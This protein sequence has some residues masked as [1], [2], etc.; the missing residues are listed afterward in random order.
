MEKAGNHILLKKLL[1]VT[2]AMFGFGYAMVPFYNKICE[3][4][5]INSD[6]AQVLAKNSQVDASRT[7]TLEFDANVDAKLPWKFVPVQKSMTVHPGEMV[8]VLYEVENQTDQNIT[9]Q[10]IPSYG[11]QLAGQYVK[12]IECFCFTGQTLKAHE[13]RQMPVMLVM[14]PAL[15]GDVNTVTLSYTFFVMPGADKAAQGGKAAVN[16]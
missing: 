9:G 16:G 4:T 6:D 7:I 12:K 10:A 8:Q 3:V 2:V 14:D 15:P 13:K 11:P 1:V 5:G